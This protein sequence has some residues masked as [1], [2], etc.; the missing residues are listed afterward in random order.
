[1]KKLKKSLALLLAMIMMVMCL[2]G[3]GEKENDKQSTENADV[4]QSTTY[5]LDIT[6]SYGNVVTLEKEPMK[7]V[8]CAPN[9]TEMMY[10]LGAGD[11][12]VGRSDYCDYPAEALEVASVGAIDNPDLEMIIALEPD[13]VIATTFSEENI[14][15]L[16]DVGIPVIVLKEETTLD[17]VYVM[18][19]DMGLILNKNQE[20]ASC[21]SDM[22]Q[23]IA[24]VQTTIEG[25][26]K[27]TVYYVV[28]YGEYGDY[29][30]G[31]DTFTGEMLSLAGG[32]NI[33][34]DI[35]GWSITLEEIIEKDPDIIIISEYMKDDFVSSP[36]YSELTAVKNGQVYSMDVNMLERQGYRNAQG[37]RELAEIFYPEAFE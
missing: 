13:V 1:M 8:S 3:C 23:T 18:L 4:T 32:E 28:G 35:S 36:N 24:D 6:D 25:L 20:A 9:I 30:A 11:K 26:D 16:K 5:P 34:K 31:G 29:T 21:I 2:V 33:A 17:G 19:T 27:P 22:K 7:V 14:Q 15:K 37:I 10:D 12:L